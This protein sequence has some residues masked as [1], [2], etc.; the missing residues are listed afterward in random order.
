MRLTKS[1]RKSVFCTLMLMIFNSCDNPQDLTMNGCA[2]PLALNYNVLADEECSTGCQ[3]SNV[4]FFG[5]KDDSLTYPITIKLG[6]MPEENLTSEVG[7]VPQ[8]CL[9]EGVSGLLSFQLT[10]SDELQWLA[11]SAQDS[12]LFSGTLSPN[13]IQSC[14]QINIAKNGRN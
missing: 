4:V 14:I 12:L 8:V 5:H 1:S 7:I 6:E 9:T 11:L 2:D 3:Y 10:S 13:P